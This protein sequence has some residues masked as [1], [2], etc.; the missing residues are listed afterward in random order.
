MENKTGE[1]TDFVKLA[2]IKHITSMGTYV[3]S[4]EALS[5]ERGL[6]SSD[7]ILSSVNRSDDRLAQFLLLPL[8]L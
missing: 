2:L 7:L 1:R 8:G 5:S 4:G 6:T 3:H